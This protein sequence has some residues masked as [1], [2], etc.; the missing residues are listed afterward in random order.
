MTPEQSL[1]AYENDPNAKETI[2]KA[3]REK[4][5]DLRPELELVHGYETA[6]MPTFYDTFNSGYGMGTGAD[7]MNP[8]ARL[9]AAAQNVALKS[10]AA[11]TARGILDTRRA[12]ME[13]LISD[14]YGQWQTGYGM[15]QNAYNRELQRQQ[16][17][18][19][20]RRWEAEMALKRLSLSGG[21]G[22][23]VINYN[24][25]TP[26]QSGGAGTSPNGG[27]APIDPA[28]E[29]AKAF[30]KMGYSPEQS[31]EMATRGIPKDQKDYSKYASYAWNA[32]V[33]GLGSQIRDIGSAGG[34]GN[35][36]DQNMQKSR[37]QFN[38]AK[39]WLSGIF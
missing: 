21:N 32:I 3:I 26:T 6:Q 9:N 28:Y 12:G 36:W 2:S 15:A 14:S 20:K 13:D 37:D 22:G 29:R 38:S 30:E 5:Q 11:R 39:N 27:K 24:G 33:P 35:W 16:M 8:M 10:R 18:E 19:D 23:T 1:A 25:G 31:V 4:Y 7:Q 34:F 17:E